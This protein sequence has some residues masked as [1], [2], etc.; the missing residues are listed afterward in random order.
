MLLAAGMTRPI[1][2]V[3]AL[4][5][6]V[7]VS[8]YAQEEPEDVPPPAIAPGAVAPAIV[9]PAPPT[10]VLVA[11]S[12]TLPPGYRLQLIEGPPKRV[13]RVGLG[14]AG[15]VLLGAVWSAN[16]MA[17]APTQ[18]WAL[19]IPLVGPFVEEGL[20]ARD[21]GLTGAGAGWVHFLL[22]TDALAQIGGLVMAIAGGSHKTVPGTQQLVIVPTGNG[23]SGH[24]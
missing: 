24:F 13:A 14:V 4:S 7:G 15:G 1:S 3:I 19:A 21:S 16:L 8:G 2:L 9:A 5:L 23:I 18:Q 22:V 17:A 6:L 10:P 20:I 12:L 11:P